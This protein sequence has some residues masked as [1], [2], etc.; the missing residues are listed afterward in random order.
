MSGNISNV[1]IAVFFLGVGILAL[2]SILARF[3][4]NHHAPVRTV[5]AVVIDKHKAEVFS[6]YS[7]NGNREKYVVVFSVGGKKKAFFVS[8]FSYEGYHLHEKG[9]LTYRGE[10]IIDFH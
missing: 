2:V 10:K 1:V 7:G 8:P 9:Q 6:Q 5:P 3:W 4:K